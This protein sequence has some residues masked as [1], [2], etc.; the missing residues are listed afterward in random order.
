MS[1][2]RVLRLDPRLDCASAGYSIANVT[3]D[4]V[5]QGAI[6]SYTFTNVMTAHTLSATFVIQSVVAHML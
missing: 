6:T 5:S 2:R 1:R 4:G 3:V